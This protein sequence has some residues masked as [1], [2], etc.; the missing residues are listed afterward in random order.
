MGIEERPVIRA[1]GIAVAA[2][3][4]TVWAAALLALGVEP[5]HALAGG[6]GAC[7]CAAVPLAVMFFAA[8]LLRDEKE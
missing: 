8:G 4:I 5:V 3:V 1:R 6:V 2:V 7:G